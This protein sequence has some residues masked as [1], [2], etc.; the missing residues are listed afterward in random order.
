M[1]FWFEQG[2]T[3]RGRS[4]KNFNDVRPAGCFKGSHDDEG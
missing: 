2:A 4:L 1:N 3:S